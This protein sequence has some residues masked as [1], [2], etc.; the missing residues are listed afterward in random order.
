[1][2]PQKVPA[3]L[4]LVHHEHENRRR[5]RYAGTGTELMHQEHENQPRERRSG[6]PIRT[7]VDPKLDPNGKHQW[8]NAR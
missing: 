4:I 5:K 2:I 7:A 1:M 6:Q 3:S 8:A